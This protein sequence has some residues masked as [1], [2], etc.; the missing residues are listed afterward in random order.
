[1][2]TMVSQQIP[3]LNP[4]NAPQEEVDFPL[5]S[6]EGKG[7]EREQS[8]LRLGLKWQGRMAKVEELGLPTRPPGKMFR[9]GILGIP[10][11]AE[12]TVGNN[13]LTLAHLT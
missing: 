9:Q 12:E 4:A 6:V 11:P 7:K 1:M 10:E 8:L 2:A 3:I 13:N 5:T